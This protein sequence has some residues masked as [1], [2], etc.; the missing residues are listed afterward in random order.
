VSDS[1]I[2]VAVA[3]PCPG[4]PHSDGDTVFLAPKLGFNAGV[5]ADSKLVDILHGSGDVEAV[6]A[7]LLATYISDGVRAWTFVDADGADVPV[8]PQTI[9]AIL[10][11]DYELGVVVAEAADPLYSKAV[12]NPLLRRMSASSPPS[13]TNGST[14]R[15]RASSAKRRTASA[16]SLTSITPTDST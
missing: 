10:L 16:P 7:A 1:L 13:P 9:Q 14:S 2:P 12:T 5:I 3:C 15:K 8:S 4:T 11:S 6:K